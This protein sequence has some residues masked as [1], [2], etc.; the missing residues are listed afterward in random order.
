[1]N[2]T[3]GAPIKVAWVEAGSE[4]GFGRAGEFGGILTV[5]F[6][7]DARATTPRTERK[8]EICILQAK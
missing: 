8:E 4:A 1:V 2:L 6:A 5:S 7:A 3:P